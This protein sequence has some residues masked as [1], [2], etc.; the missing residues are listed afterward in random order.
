MIRVRV[1]LLGIFYLLLGI[2]LAAQQAKF[3]FFNTTDGLEGNFTL[4]VVQDQQG[5]IW[6]INQYA[7]HRY[8]GRTFIKY[9]TP[10]LDSL[11]NAIPIRGL[12]PYQDSLILVQSDY[13]LSYFNP[14]QDTW[15]P[16]DIPGASPHQF[17]WTVIFRMGPGDYALNS[18]DENNLNKPQIWRL[19][20]GI[21]SK[22]H[23]PPQWTPAVGKYSWLVDADN[24]YYLINDDTLRAFTPTFEFKFEI[25]LKD[26]PTQNHH[27]QEMRINPL[28]GILMSF[29]GKIFLLKKNTSALTPHPLNRF[30]DQNEETVEDF[31]PDENGDIWACG[32]EKLL[33]F[34]QARTDT[35]FH[36]EADLQKLLEVSTTLKSISKDNTQTLWM[37]TS[38]GL[39]NMVP[40]QKLFENYLHDP[41]ELCM[42]YCSIRGIA[43]DDAG[44]LYANCYGSIFQFDSREKRDFRAIFPEETPF[45][46]LYHKGSIFT[47]SGNRLDPQ[48]RKVTQI[49][50]STPNHSDSGLLTHDAQGRLW[51][52]YGS[53]IFCLTEDKTAPMWMPI[54]SLPY[55]GYQGIE[56]MELG[57]H[58]GKIWIGL[59][60]KLIVLD[61]ETHAFSFYPQELP[62]Q[63][64]K[65]ILAIYEDQAGILW[66]GTDKGFLK[67]DPQSSQALLFTSNNGLPDDFVCGIL[68]EGD[69]CLWLSTNNGLSRFQKKE[70]S[71]INFFEE[72]GLTFN[73]FNRV[74][75]YQAK[76]GRMYFG[77]LEGINAFYP[78]EVMGTLR[79]LNEQAKL[80]LSSFERTDERENLLIKSYHFPPGKEIQLHHWDRSF[81]FEYALTDYTNPQETHYSFLMEGYEDNWSSPSKFN[82]TRYSSLPSGSYTFRVKARDSKGRWH[83]QELA[84]RVIMH[85]PWWE[86]TLAYFI[87]AVLFL[88]LAFGV[89]WFLRRRLLLQ[90]Q[91]QLKQQEAARLKELD[92]FKSKLY[93]NLTHEF[94]T[95]LTVILGMTKQLAGGS[96]QTAEKRAEGLGLIQRNGESLLQLINQLLDLS[97]LENKSFILHLQQADIIPYLRYLTES[98]QSFAESKKIDLRFQSEEDCLIMDFDPEQVKHIVVNLISNAVKF[99][100]ESGKI[101]L[102]CAVGSVQSKNP[103]LPTANSLLLSVSDTGIGI[104]P[105]NLP[106]VFDRFYQVDGS[107]TRKGEGTG[108]GLAHTRELVRLMGGTISVESEVGKGSIFTISLPIQKDPA[109]ANS[110]TSIQVKEMADLTIAP[111]ARPDSIPAEKHISNGDLPL[112]LIVEDNHDIVAYL[113]SFL[114]DHYQLVVAFNGAEGIKKAL[115]SIPDL[116]ISDVMMPEKDGF[117]LCE[118]LKLDERTSH[119]PL[120]LLTA[121]ADAASRIAG[122]KRGADVYL[123]KPF[124]SEELLVHLASLLARQKRLAAYFSQN[125]YISE[126]VS[127]EE[128]NAI[129]I[130]HAFMQK[131]NGIIEAN[132]RDENFALPQLC[133]ALAMS[134]SQ[135]FRKMKALIDESPSPYLK[136]Y[137]LRKAKE[138]L[139]AGDITVSEA[140]WQVGFRELAHFSK[141]FQAEFGLSPSEVGE[142]QP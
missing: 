34:Y 24:T 102:Q 92:S 53:Q 11:G 118:T 141:S 107:Q 41:R 132:Y 125:L 6:L 35:L 52:S 3:S 75:Y 98:F 109:L 42:G 76:D 122:I 54:D 89:F 64:I 59:N 22:V 38:L 134:R 26:D 86:T 40:Q 94:R 142:V 117:E 114:Q 61:T 69:S 128:A 71:F 9:P 18:M 131:V 113:K 74:S 79:Q 101:S 67:V 93:T 90:N 135:L 120:I 36:Y 21:L 62:S 57:Q 87:Y 84:I 129:Q 49:K 63:H 43:E 126:N 103:N 5:F 88:C 28:G 27:N 58:S 13:Q 81:A 66:L 2:E 8:D 17:R 91:L 15:T 1:V 85:P 136:S 68:P 100:P 97:K 121:K 45:D 31:L 32:G 60:G 10:P 37:G 104:P 12:F 115:E 108:I 55:D 123:A 105:Q 50:G 124:D 82:F 23:V 78:D 33:Y 139:A 70:K 119:I 29:E 96:W 44:Y 133:E 73:E 138:L 83:P 137:R 65:R 30:L 4:H 46:L 72:D 14:Q 116:I 16:I 48:S 130:E 106:Y 127:E 112:L 110:S 95:P 56:A 80:L 20:N 25:P 39:L 77:G 111:F 7:L 140:A 99:T 47:N 19:K 51:R